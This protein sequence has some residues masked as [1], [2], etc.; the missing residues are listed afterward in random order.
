MF[1]DLMSWKRISFSCLIAFA[2]QPAA[3]QSWS[4]LGPDGG[5]VL[6][7]IQDEAS[8]AT[9]YAGT[10]G[11]FFRSTDGGDH[12]S[13]MGPVSTLLATGGWPLMQ[14]TEVPSRLYT[15][16]SGVIWRSDDNG[17]T[18]AAVST[19]PAG[20]VVSALIDVPVAS[21]RLYALSQRWGV[22]Y[23]QDAGQHWVMHNNGLPPG[24]APGALAIS[25]ANPNIALL[26]R[27]PENSYYQTDALYRSIDGGNSWL[28]VNLGTQDSSSWPPVVT[29]SSGSRAY[30]TVGANL[31]RSNDFGATWATSGPV[32]L[33]PWTLSPDPI[34]PDVLLSGR[35]DG[36]FR[37]IDAGITW[38]SSSD[39]LDS[40]SVSKAGVKVLVRDWSDA[41]GQ[42]LWAA[43]ERSGIFRST[44]GGA[45]W[46][47]H[48]EGLAANSFRTVA[49]HP[50]HPATVYAGTGEDLAVVGG[51]HVLNI[52]QDGGAT[53]G[54]SDLDLLAGQLRDIAIDPTTTQDIASTHLYAVGSFARQS[55]RNG[56]VYKSIDGGTHWTRADQGLPLWFGQVGDPTPY[57]GRVRS[58]VLDA[59]SCATPPASG[60]CT[61][62]PLRTLYIT[63]YG[64]PFQERAR[65]ARSTDAG[66][67]WTDINGDLPYSWN[68]GESAG[69]D[70]KPTMLRLD[71]VATNILY[72]GTYDLVYADVGATPPSPRLANGF[73]R[74]DDGG[75]H[76]LWRS[77]GLPMRNTSTAYDVA[78]IAVHPRRSGV[79]WAAINDLAAGTP[80]R[81]YKTE[82]GGEHWDFTCHASYPITCG[83]S[84]CDVRTLTVD[85]AAPDVIY[86]GGLATDGTGGCLLRS[87]D[88]GGWWESLYYGAWANGMT[89]FARDPAD[90][91]RFVIG[92]NT[93]VWQLRSPSDKI[94]VDDFGR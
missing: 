87:E 35:T 28:P 5:R 18:W 68:D 29:F 84:D 75:Q 73:F 36:V 42:K 78:A 92:A 69:E 72:L 15:T 17:T 49:V 45:H 51:G 13:R 93:G 12:W 83:M 3:A 43:T 31:L 89:A 37:S 14:D 81:I 79:L 24:F 27:D 57:V 55:A 59:R 94:F 62:G 47:A 60:P 64:N 82:D 10:Q 76:W 90:S 32:A 34:A 8:A 53:W 67:S 33:T 58:V 39:G 30:V 46:T 20:D 61:E 44:D 19:M 21:D 4:Y 1:V 66:T 7:L 65:I 48:N 41:S 22:L 50:R 38:T 25:G 23:S 91:S 56:G 77:S 26:R 54:T 86:A 88:G 2:A 52:S 63:S 11:G 80:S 6:S 85:P 9:L 70:L 40:N 16:N 74:S 71:A